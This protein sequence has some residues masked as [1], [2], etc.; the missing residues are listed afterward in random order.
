MISLGAI[1]FGLLGIIWLYGL[2]RRL[3]DTVAPLATNRDTAFQADEG[4][5]CQQSTHVGSQT[6]I[7]SDSRNF[8]QPRQ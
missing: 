4:Y 5:D 1:L 6:S 7:N 3:P 8:K 2:G